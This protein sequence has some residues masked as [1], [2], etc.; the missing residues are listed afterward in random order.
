MMKLKKIRFI[1]L[2]LVLIAISF[3]FLL[4][5]CKKEEVP[6]YR[7]EMGMEIGT[8]WPERK[9]VLSARRRLIFDN[10]Y[11]EG[12]L[13]EENNRATFDFDNCPGISISVEFYIIN[14]KND[15]V[16]KTITPPEDFIPSTDFFGSVFKKL[17]VGYDSWQQ[18]PA[19][20]NI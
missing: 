3:S 19:E 18:I 15:K 20:Y 13:T 14:N 5:G 4:F 12:M 8:Y 17:K 7:V 2:L 10:R 1:K 9:T 11:E 6:T 16:V